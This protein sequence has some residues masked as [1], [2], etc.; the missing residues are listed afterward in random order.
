ML[1]CRL[2]FEKFG[3]APVYSSHAPYWSVRDFYSV[4][5]EVAGCVAYAMR[6]RNETDAPEPQD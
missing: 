4:P 2:A 1:R 5:R 6:Q 3:L